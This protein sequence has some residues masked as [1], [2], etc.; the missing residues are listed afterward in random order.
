[1]SVFLFKTQRCDSILKRCDFGEPCTVS[2]QVIFETSM[3]PFLQ[4]RRM[5]VHILTNAWVLFKRLALFFDP[6]KHYTSTLLVSNMA[7]YELRLWNRLQTECSHASNS[8]CC[9]RILQWDSVSL[10]HSRFQGSVWTQVFETWFARH[11]S[12]MITWFWQEAPT[13]GAKCRKVTFAR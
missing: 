10:F 9:W 6:N 4:S 8:S 5:E 3:P 2:I 11:N 12:N 13:R 7:N 1:M